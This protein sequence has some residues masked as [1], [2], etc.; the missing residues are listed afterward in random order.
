MSVSARVRLSAAPID[1]GVSDLVPGNP[2]PVE[3]LDCVS[4]AGYTGCELGTHG[5]FGFTPDAI[6]SLFS[7][8]HL[9]V[10]ASW[11]DVDLSKP[12]QQAAAAEI[13]LIASFLQAGGATVLNISDKIVPERAAVVG[14]VSDFPKT[15]YT[16]S[17][18]TQVPRTLNEIHAIASARGVR[19]AFHF[20]V[21]THV[22][23]NEEVRRLID[24]I[25]D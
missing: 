23:S 19:V 20:H 3:M 14:R 4:A 16:D 7:P 5:Y 25:A 10:T 2:E 1:W 21:A 15:G 6:L 24:S 11:Y 17:D 13:D 8:R 9:A 12:L 18:W 22:E